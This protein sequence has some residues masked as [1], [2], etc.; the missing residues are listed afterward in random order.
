M[1][2]ERSVFR[3]HQRSLT[4]KGCKICLIILMV[5]FSGLAYFSLTNSVLMHALFINKNDILLSL[6]T[7]QLFVTN[8]NAIN[9]LST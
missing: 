3:L 2:F 6:I 7:Q 9:Q 4:T 1:E 8:F 5:I